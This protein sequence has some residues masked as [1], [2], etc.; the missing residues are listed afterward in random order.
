MKATAACP[1]TTLIPF[2]GAVLE[3]D[4]NP[5]SEPV[6]GRFHS[7]PAHV[8]LTLPTVVTVTVLA[9]ALAWAKTQ[10]SIS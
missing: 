10:H 6:M 9:A 3:P 1:E 2:D 5:P 7:V 8:Q 4:P